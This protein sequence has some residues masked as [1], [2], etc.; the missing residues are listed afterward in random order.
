MLVQVN[1]I[2]L[3]CTFEHFTVDTVVLFVAYV[4]YVLFCYKYLLYDELIEIILPSFDASHIP[5]K[6]P[7]TKNNPLVQSQTY[8]CVNESVKI[9]GNIYLAIVYLKQDNIIIF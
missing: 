2:I 1:T 5:I 3:I 4:A 7:K 9:C 8:S 6:H